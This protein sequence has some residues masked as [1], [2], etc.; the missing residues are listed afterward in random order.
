MAVG[1]GA[2]ADGGVAGGGLGVGVVV[3]AVGEVGAVLEEE[4]EAAIFEVGAIAVEV[5][6]AELI[7]DEDDGE[8]GMVVVGAGRDGCCWLAAGGFSTLGS[9]FACLRVEYGGSDQQEEQEGCGDSSKGR[10]REIEI[11]QDSL[12]NHVNPIPRLFRRARVQGEGSLAL[13]N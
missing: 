9:F 1:V 5:V 13:V 4:V 11:A 7:D 10:W 8:L 2:G 6:A 12:L 3:V